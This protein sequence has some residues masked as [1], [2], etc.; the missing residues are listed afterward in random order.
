MPKESKAP[1]KRAPMKQVEPKATKI[2]LIAPESG[3]TPDN[4][5]TCMSDGMIFCND[6]KG[7]KRFEFKSSDIICIDPS[8][9]IT[10]EQLKNP[11]ANGIIFVN[12]LEGLRLL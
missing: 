5:S 2:I 9:G 10:Y 11:P 3:I 4:L 6:V 12:S 1:L 7:I 8:S